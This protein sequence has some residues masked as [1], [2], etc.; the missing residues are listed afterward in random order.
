MRQCGQKG[1]IEH[2]VMGNVKPDKCGRNVSFRQHAAKK[3]CDRTWEYLALKTLSVLYT[4]SA[5]DVFNSGFQVLEVLGA[6]AP[7]PNTKEHREC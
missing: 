6:A 4:T 1:G 5:L 2:P 3:K 7:G